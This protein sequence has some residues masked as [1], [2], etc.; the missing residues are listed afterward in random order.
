MFGKYF[1]S[2]SYQGSPRNISNFANQTKVTIIQLMQYSEHESSKYGFEIL[3]CTNMNFL[4][5]TLTNESKTRAKGR[6]LSLGHYRIYFYTLKGALQKS[7][8]QATYMS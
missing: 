6:V 1:N 2:K 4:K 5:D 8:L 7:H 3:I